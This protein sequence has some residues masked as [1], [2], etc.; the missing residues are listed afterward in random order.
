MCLLYL[1]SEA[2]K[3]FAPHGGLP[4]RVV[5]VHVNHDLQPA[6]KDMVNKVAAFARRLDVKDVQ[7]KIQWGRSPYPPRPAPNQPFEEMARDA[8]SFALLSAMIEE[9]NLRYIA[10]G[11][12]ADDQLETALI[13]LMRGSGRQGASGMRRLRLWGMGS[14]DRSGLRFSGTMGMIRRIVRPLLDIP[15]VKKN[16]LPNF[17]RLTRCRIGFSQLVR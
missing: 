8:R 14:D 10:Y 11:H 16:Q 13:R 7:V 12:H 6:N 2:I 4:S 15:K 5:S 1:F 3:H 9:K 17:Q